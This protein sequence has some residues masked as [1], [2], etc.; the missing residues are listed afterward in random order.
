MH[1][2]PKDATT[3]FIYHHVEIVKFPLYWSR[4]KGDIPGQHLMDASGLHDW[5]EPKLAGVTG[6]ATVID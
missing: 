4:Q 1:L 2:R 5:D 3:L 6:S